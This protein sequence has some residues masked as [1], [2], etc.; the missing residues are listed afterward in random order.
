MN[1][2]PSAK[3]ARTISR[4]TIIQSWPQLMTREDRDVAEEMQRILSDEGIQILVAAETLNV[5]GR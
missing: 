4:V 5:N 2:V 3:K 1:G